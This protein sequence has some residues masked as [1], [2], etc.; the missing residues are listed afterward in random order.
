MGKQHLWELE[1]WQDWLGN[2]PAAKFMREIKV[3]NPLLHESVCDK[4]RQFSEHWPI[5]AFLQSQYIKYIQGNLCEYRITAEK[6]E[7]RM[8]GIVDYRPD[9]PPRF[10]CFHCFW[11]KS[12]KMPQRELEVALKRLE[13]YKGQK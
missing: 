4:I 8:L 3:S 12:K 13:Q 9:Q 10:L 7:L 11:K 5:E 6:N 2:C 1:F